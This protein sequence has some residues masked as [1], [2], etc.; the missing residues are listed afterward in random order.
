MEA[1]EQTGR[2][3]VSAHLAVQ[4]VIT[5]AQF[6]H[7]RA[8]ELGKRIAAG[9]ETMGAHQKPEWK[10]LVSAFEV[11]ARELNEHMRDEES[12][13]LDHVQFLMVRNRLVPGALSDAHE[14][15]DVL[16]REHDTMLVL[17]KRLELE[18]NASSNLQLTPEAISVRGLMRE[19]MAAFTDHHDFEQHALVPVLQPFLR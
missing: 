17:R 3:R 7:P 6:H 14:A 1:I 9:L 18:L 8:R 19:F 12:I 13:V 2:D 10:A 15:F 11:F 5:V 16:M 4:V